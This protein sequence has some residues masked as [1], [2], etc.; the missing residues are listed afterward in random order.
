MLHLRYIYRSLS[1]NRACNRCNRAASSARA[2]PA[3]CIYIYIK[4]LYTGVY[5]LYFCCMLCCSCLQRLLGVFL[6]HALSAD[7]LYSSIHKLQQFFIIISICMLLHALLQ[8][9]HALLQ[10]LLFVFTCGGSGE[11]SRAPG[12]IAMTLLHLFFF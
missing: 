8:L 11:S 1:C 12:S 6:L 3:L 4:A 2:P 10:I 9:L 5:A 7:A